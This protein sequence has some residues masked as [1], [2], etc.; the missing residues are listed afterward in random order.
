MAPSHTLPAGGSHIHDTDRGHVNAG[1]VLIML[2]RKFKA[3]NK[4]IITKDF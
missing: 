4:P 2:F 3:F 1:V